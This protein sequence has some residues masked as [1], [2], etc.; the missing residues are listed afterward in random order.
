MQDSIARHCDRGSIAANKA[1][2]T[3]Q[4][5]YKMATSDINLN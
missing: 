5:E 1:K 3:I 4:Y 2:V